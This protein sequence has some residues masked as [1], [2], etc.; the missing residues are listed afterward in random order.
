MSL[1]EDEI[2]AASDILARADT[3]ERHQLA[4]MLAM[5]E[6][7]RWRAARMV[8]TRRDGNDQ[9]IALMLV[10]TDPRSIARVL[11]LEADLDAEEEAADLGTP[12][13]GGPDVPAP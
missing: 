6:A 8:L 2:S 11:A 7:H 4:L 1:T 5:A 9:P 10:T 3:A 12:P 13:D